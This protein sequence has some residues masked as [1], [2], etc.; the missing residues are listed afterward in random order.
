MHRITNGIPFPYYFFH[1]FL[2]FFHIS[3]SKERHPGDGM[4]SYTID[5]H[6]QSATTSYRLAK[7]KQKLRSPT[8]TK[9]KTKIKTKK[10]TED[11]KISESLLPDILSSTEQS[12]DEVNSLYSKSKEDLII[13]VDSI[14]TQLSLYENHN[15]QLIEEKM[16][17]SQQL[18]VQTQVNLYVPSSNSLVHH[19]LGRGLPKKVCSKL[20]IKTPD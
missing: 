10:K 11:I 8:L 1:I 19:F 5:D 6:I 4:E 2:P 15:N 12:Q 18:G 7:Q 16:K 14:K 9:V 3:V 20:T 17:L 13:L